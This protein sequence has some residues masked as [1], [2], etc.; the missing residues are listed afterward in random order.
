[1]E[2][3][4]LHWIFFTLFALSFPLL[5]FITFHQKCDWLGDDGPEFY[6]LPFAYRSQIPLGSSMS[7]EFYRLGY[8]GN[9][10]FYFLFALMIFKTFNLLNVK[11][12]LKSFISKASKVTI[13]LFLILTI[14]SS[15]IIDWNFKWTDGR[16]QFEKGA[17]KG[18]KCDCKLEFFFYL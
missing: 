10:L 2:I 17:G 6:G 7:G 13:M 18:M 4:K 1:M 16:N 15:F 9:V 14:F 3:F 8:L 11:P 12:K 5:D